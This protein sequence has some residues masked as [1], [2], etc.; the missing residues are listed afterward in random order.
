VLLRDVVVDEA[1]VV[2]FVD[3]V[4]VDELLGLGG[5]CGSV[6][7]VS[8][9]VL[10]LVGFDGLVVVLSVEDHLV[11]GSV[12]VDRV[13]GVDGV[14]NVVDVVEVIDV[15]DVVE[16]VD[17][18]ND[19]EDDS[20][21]VFMRVLV[22]SKLVVVSM[23][24]VVSILVVEEELS[25]FSSS[26]NEGSGLVGLPSPSDVVTVMGRNEIEEELDMAGMLLSS[27][28]P[29]KNFNQGKKGLQVEPSKHSQVVEAAARP[30]Q[31]G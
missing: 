1:F 24:V 12:D 9:D 30:V 29:P 4:V 26:M 28:K 17:G 20:V 22:V 6:D 10:V 25:G 7:V 5:I 23:F 2:I 18:G 3:V 16:M 21:D 11:S 13:V 27:I 15:V 19:L 14:V 8:V 31:R